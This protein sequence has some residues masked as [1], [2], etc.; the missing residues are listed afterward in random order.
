MNEVN[1]PLQI[2]EKRERKIEWQNCVISEHPRCEQQ[3]KASQRN[4]SQRQMEGLKLS[5][6]IRND[7]EK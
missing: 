6:I 4:R 1:K 5:K 3:S 2:Y 7:N